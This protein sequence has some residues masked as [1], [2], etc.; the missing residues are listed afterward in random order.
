MQ[1]SVGGVAEAELRSAWMA[2]GGRPHA[3]SRGCMRG[4]AAPT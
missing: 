2:E 3:T 1:R 4:T